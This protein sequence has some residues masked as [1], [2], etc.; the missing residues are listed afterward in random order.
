MQGGLI[1]RMEQSLA[2]TLLLPFQMVP[3]IAVHA[4]SHYSFC[5]GVIPPVIL[6]FLVVLKNRSSRCCSI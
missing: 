5:L 1:L 6:P 4:A 3:K 2:G